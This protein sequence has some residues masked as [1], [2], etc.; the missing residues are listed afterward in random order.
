MPT[1]YRS[2][3]AVGALLELRDPRIAVVAYGGGV[4]TRR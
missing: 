1:F 3:G 4:V 2:G